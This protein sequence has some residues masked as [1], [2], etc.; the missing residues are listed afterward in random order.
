M[1]FLNKVT[2]FLVGVSGYVVANISLLYLFCFMAGVGPFKTMNDGVPGPFVQSILINLSLIALFGLHHTGGARRFIKE[3]IGRL[4]SPTI[5]RSIYLI[6]TS[7]L[8]VL[9][10]HYWQPI[11]IVLWSFDHPIVVAGFRIA[12]VGAILVMTVAT[13]QID[14][15]TFFGVRKPLDRLLKRNPGQTPF[16]ARL[17]YGLVRHP[18]S[19][20]WLVTPWLVPEFTVGQL[21]FALGTATYVFIATPFEEADLRREIGTEYDDYCKGTPRFFPAIRR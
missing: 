9:L 13:F 3:I 18:I 6:I 16:T 1:N 7:A 2:L 21:V 19:F 4:A 5:E 10:I 14:N 17:L 20:G 12:F 11:P 8:V 15:L